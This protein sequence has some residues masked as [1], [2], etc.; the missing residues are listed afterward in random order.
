MS[1]DLCCQKFRPFF[2]ACRIALLSQALLIIAS[3][4]KSPLYNADDEPE[5]EK[6]G[7]D[8]SPEARMQVSVALSKM[9]EETKSNKQAKTGP[10]P[11]KYKKKREVYERMQAECIR[12]I[13]FTSDIATNVPVVYMLTAVIQGVIDLA[14]SL[15]NCLSQP[16]LKVRLVVGRHSHC[17]KRRLCLVDGG[18]QGML[19]M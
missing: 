18:N 12:N 19:R 17:H 16:E 15:P 3:C 10:I 6:K 7:I 11:A 9:W 5:S 13:N 2:I 4:A 1:A 14:L 8:V